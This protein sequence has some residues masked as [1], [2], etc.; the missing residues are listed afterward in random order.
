[1]LYNLGLNWTLHHQ[2]FCTDFFLLIHL[3]S[4]VTQTWTKIKSQL[5]DVDSPDTELI[6]DWIEPLGFVIWHNLPY[7]KCFQRMV[8]VASMY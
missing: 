8:A 7:F 1:M 5:T 2:K 3:S 6:H 4:N